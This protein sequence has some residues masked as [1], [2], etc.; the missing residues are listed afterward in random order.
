MLDNSI[1]IITTFPTSQG[2]LPET[3]D[4]ENVLLKMNITGKG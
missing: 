4:N 1:L 3:I 2:A